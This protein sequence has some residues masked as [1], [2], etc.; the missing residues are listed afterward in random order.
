MHEKLTSFFVFDYFD[1]LTKTK[2]ECCITIYAPEM[3]TFLGDLNKSELVAMLTSFYTC[4][5]NPAYRTKSGT[6]TS[7]KNVC[8]NLLAC[9][10][11]EWLTLGTTTDEIAGGF[12]GRF[13]YVY[14]DSTDRSFPFPEDFVTQ[15][16]IDLRK[17]LTE[18]LIHIS[19]IK[20]QFSISD[21]AK[22]EYIV[23]YNKRKEE[24]KDE[25]LVGYYSRKRDLVFKIAM[26]VSV[27]QDDYLYIDEDI[28]HTTWQ[29][30]SQ[31]EARMADTFSGVVEDPALKYKD[32]V[33]SQLARAPGLKLTRAELLR[34]NWHKFDGMILDRIIRNLEEAR[35]IDVGS[36]V[37]GK[38]RQVV[39]KL[40]DSI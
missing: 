4:P 25:R 37:A 38:S 3:K 33:L 30:L 27:A 9:S 26:L 28:L 16:V 39:Y 20:G 35:V 23:W 10:T 2:G 24:C 7:F 36:M 21:Q 8:V 18:D 11:P 19:T 34:T 13:V 17:R 1:K 40:I 31:V 5:D 22:A 15:D 12:T 14:E 6:Q 29:L 32:A